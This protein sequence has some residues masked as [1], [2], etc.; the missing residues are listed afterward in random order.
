MMKAVS[1]IEP[2]MDRREVSHTTYQMRVP[3]KQF[4]DA[5]A[6]ELDVHCYLQHAFA[7]DLCP[8]G[9]TVLDVC[10]GRG[11]LIP[12]LRYRGSAPRL[13]VGVDAEPRNA[14][15]KDGADPRRESE[16][17]KD[18]W[19]FRTVFVEALVDAMAGKVADLAVGD[20]GFD[21]IVYTSAIEHMQPAAQEASLRECY[22]LSKPSTVL[23]LSC[24]V[25]AEG[26]SGFDAQ[27]AAHVYEPKESE[28][29]A[30]LKAAGWK[31]L[32]RHGLCTGS[33]AYRALLKGAELQEAE[34]IYKMLP[35]EFALPTIAAL[36][37]AS[38]QE[39]AYVCGRGQSG[40]FDEV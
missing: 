9:G 35:R 18:G 10:C 28:L 7:A 14:R 30:W 3:F 8:A 6:T 40:L 2:G 32:A 11:L 19:G 12:F 22:R 13:Y 34:R 16:I 27:Y 15:W 5:V 17:K 4:A 1:K 21:L 37:P 29:Q 36:F 26:R 20:V 38:A 24:P 31:V 39:V 33:K 25:T 23:Y